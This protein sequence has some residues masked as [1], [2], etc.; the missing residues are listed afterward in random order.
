MGTV[1]S[2]IRPHRCQRISVLFHE[3]FEVYFTLVCNLYTNYLDF[4]V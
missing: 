1:M 2:K 4:S 3:F